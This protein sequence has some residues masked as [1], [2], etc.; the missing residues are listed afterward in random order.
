MANALFSTIFL[1]SDGVMQKGKIGMS[2]IK[3]VTFVSNET[4]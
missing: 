2:I 3:L 1:K 4:L